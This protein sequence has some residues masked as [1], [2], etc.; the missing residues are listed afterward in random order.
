M[1]FGF[2]VDGVS[3][4]ASLPGLFPRL[5][6]DCPHVFLGPLRAPIPPTAPSATIARACLPAIRQLESRRA[7]RIVVLIDREAA[8]ACSSEIA[9]DVEAAVLAATGIGVTVVIKDRKFEN[10]LVSDVDAVRGLRA[11]FALAAADV[12]RIA[13]NRS[14]RADALA[15]LK[16]SAIRSSY[17]KVQDSKRILQVAEPLRMAANSRSFRKFLRT[18]DHVAYRLQSRA[19]A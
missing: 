19:P 18:V 8:T 16:R 9:A 6:T 11:R 10:W 17:D 2:V 13:P 1:R 4:F 3:E 12:N 14:D 7:D 5:V 15:I